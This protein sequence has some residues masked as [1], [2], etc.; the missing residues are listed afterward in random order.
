MIGS[1]VIA[2]SPALLLSVVFLPLRGDE[3][4]FRNDLVSDG[5]D[6]LGGAMGSEQMHELVFVFAMA[7]VPRSRVRNLSFQK[8]ISGS[9]RAGSLHFPHPLEVLI[10]TVINRL[11]VV[12]G[13]EVGQ[14]L[15]FGRFLMA[16]EVKDDAA[17]VIGIVGLTTPHQ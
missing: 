15:A 5:L 13:P 12:D 17:E 14:D 8:E 7:V 1:E 16:V 4:A 10:D 9:F 6:D 3:G 11:I 2:A